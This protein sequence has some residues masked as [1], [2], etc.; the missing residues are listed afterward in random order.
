MRMN[1]GPLILGLVITGVVDAMQGPTVEYSADSYMETADAVQQGP[2]YVTPSME[3]REYVEG[4]QSM[5]MIIRKD[6]KL[7]WMLM[8]DDKMYME[9]KFPE[10]GRKDDLG[11]Y[12]IER[13][14]LGS[15]T[16][17]GVKTTKSKIIMTGPNGAKM[18]G[19][20]WTTQE[21]VVVKLDAIAADKNKKERFKIELQNLKIGK[22]DPSLF[23]IPGDY[24][25][26]DMM[27]GLGAMM[28][29]GDDDGGDDGGNEGGDEPQ[30]PKAKEKKKRFNFKS[31]K[32]AIDMVK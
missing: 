20:A 21:G 6:E 8:P 31:L 18:G 23:Q 2:A 30:E 4:G 28:M 16:V 27:S 12:E 5:V 32:D 25:K 15:E 3:R 11:A 17:N 29:G 7:V 26:M 9:M 19:L 22:Q 24:T 10:E 13:T 1:I 14:I